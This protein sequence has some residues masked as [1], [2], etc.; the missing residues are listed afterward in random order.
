MW[1]N[2]K[3]FTYFSEREHGQGWGAERE[4]DSPWGSWTWGLIPGTQG[5]QLAPKA[6]AYLLAQLSHP[7]IPVLISLTIV[8]LSNFGY[9][10][11]LLY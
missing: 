2:F 8:Y 1:I 6:D 3:D 7:G 10:F 4:A 9:I 11:E 5:S